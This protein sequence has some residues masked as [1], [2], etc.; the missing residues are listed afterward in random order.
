MKCLKTWLLALLPKSSESGYP[1]TKK[2]LGRL[3]QAQKD[4]DRGF[5]YS[6]LDTP[7]D[8]PWTDKWMFRCDQ[9]KQVA[10]I[11]EHKPF[12]HLPDCPMKKPLQS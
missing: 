9:C 7:L 6:A 8:A 12:P 5:T 10:D 2:A 11:C 4:I 3:D 1:F